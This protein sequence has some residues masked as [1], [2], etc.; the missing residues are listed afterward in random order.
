MSK[1]GFIGVS[2]LRGWRCFGIFALASILGLPI[3]H[4]DTSTLIPTADAYVQNG[5]NDGKN[6]GSATELRIRTSSTTSKNY[7]TYLKFDAS[8]IGGGVTSAKL[9]I[10]AKLSASGTVSSTAYAV[11]NTSWSETGITWDNKP[12]RGAS[13]GSVTINT[14][15][16]GWIEVDVTTYV[17]SE[18][19]AGRKVLSFN[20]HSSKK[21]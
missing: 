20:Y 12:T 14:T 4:A 15:S 7:D 6:Y 1:P 11:S 13:L 16:Y 10:Y 8:P 5:D 9:R 3:V 17:K 19:A 18:F 21:Y 2:V